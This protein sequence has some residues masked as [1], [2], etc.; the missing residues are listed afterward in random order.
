MLGLRT[1]TLLGTGLLWE[2]CAGFANWTYFVVRFYCFCK[3]WVI[4]D[5]WPYLAFGPFGEYSSLRLL[6]QIQ[7]V[8]YDR[9]MC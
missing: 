9:S 8:D 3:L 2:Y 5:F 1:L 7:V 6:E 4:L